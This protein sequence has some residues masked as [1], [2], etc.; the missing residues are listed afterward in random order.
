VSVLRDSTPWAMNVGDTVR[1]G[2]IITT[3]EDGYAR[4][5]VAD[6]STFEVFPNSQVTFR[7]NSGDWRELVEVWLGRIKVHIQKLSGGRP[8]PNR[9]GTPTAVISVK[10]TIFHVTVEDDGGTTYVMVEE[11]LVGVRHKTM[12]PFKDVDLNGGEALRVFPNVPLAQRMIDKGT[13]AQRVAKSASDIL[14]E[15]LWRRSIGGTGSGT[16]GGP[17]GVP[18]GSGGGSPGDTK[19]KDPPPPPPPPPPPSGPPP[20]P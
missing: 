13:V 8:N 16:S 15:I 3:G 5:E 14:A 2:Q 10:G 20:P 1:P 12:P 19:S 18:G 9:V 11:G 4:F 7:Q 6:G 17:G